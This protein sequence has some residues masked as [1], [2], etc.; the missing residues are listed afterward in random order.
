MLGH[1]ARDMTTGTKRVVLDVAP[2]RFSARRVDVWP[3][4]TRR[5]YSHLS[6]L[7]FGTRVQRRDV[8]TTFSDPLCSVQLHRR[9]V[10]QRTH[11]CTQHHLWGVPVPRTVDEHSQQ[12]GLVARR[13]RKRRNRQ[14][15]SHCFFLRAGVFLPQHSPRPVVELPRSFLHEVQ[16]WLGP[17]FDLGRC[18]QGPV[19]I[20][21]I[22]YIYICI[23][24]KGSICSYIHL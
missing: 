10:L 7:L 13:P 20:M 19:N 3:A 24:C 5:G 17:P 12:L 8:E 11:S 15:C 6:R 14:S 16:K 9:Y 22:L 21:R 4:T 18:A 2:G 23:W 1:A